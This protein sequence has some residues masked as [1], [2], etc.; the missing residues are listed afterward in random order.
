[1]S[2]PSPPPAPSI[3]SKIDLSWKQRV[4]FPIL[5]AVPILALFGIFGEARTH[6][7]ASSRSIDMEVSYPSRFRYRQVQP[8]RVTVR[9]FSAVLADTIRVS[10]DT[11]YVS[12]FSSVRFDPAAKSAYTVDLT[13]VKPSESRLV[14]VELWGQDYG[15]HRGTVVARHNAD[16]AI[17]HLT[18]LVFP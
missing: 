4:G 8:L 3:N 16:S 2:L 6:T 18:T 13:D 14:S 17:V 1:M 7:H 12:R 9:N 10:F 11:A 5:I 15:N